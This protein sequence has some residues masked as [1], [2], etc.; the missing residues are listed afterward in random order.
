L[1]GLGW[2]TEP[3]FENDS[4]ATRG[5]SPN[6]RTMRAAVSAICASCSAVGS[7]L[8]VVSPQ[9]TDALVEHQH[10]HAAQHPGARVRAHVSSAGRTVS[11][12]VAFTPDSTAST[13]PRASMQH[14]K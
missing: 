11:G 6:V 9:N 12:Y 14:P 3:K 5:S 10:V 4:I 8:I 2:R 7:T 1:L 13:S